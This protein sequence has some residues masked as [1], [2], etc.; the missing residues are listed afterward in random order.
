MRELPRDAE[1]KRLVGEVLARPEYARYREGSTRWLELFFEWLRSLYASL[2]ELADARPGLYLAITIGLLL[3][4][5]LLVA[6]IAWTISTALRQTPGVGTTAVRGSGSRDFAAEAAAL[7]SRG[8]YLEAAHAMLLATLAYSAQ[9]RL[10]ELRPEDGN[11]T[12]RA[13][14]RR[15]G[16]P[17]PLQQRLIELIDRTE[18]GWFGARGGATERSAELYS[19]WQDAYAKLRGGGT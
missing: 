15:S 7:A 4:A 8:S 3:V 11:R 6:H 5:L 17:A 13:K 19:E 1:V 16:L 9:A 18:A 14:L 2:G 10:L 12:I